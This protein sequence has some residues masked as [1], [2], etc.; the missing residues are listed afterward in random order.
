MEQWKKTLFSLFLLQMADP[1]LA[2]TLGKMFSSHIVLQAEPQ[3][4]FSSPTLIYLLYVDTFSF[5]LTLKYLSKWS[6]FS[7]SKLSHFLVVV[8]I[9][10]WLVFILGWRGASYFSDALASLRPLLFGKFFE[11]QI[12]SESISENVIGLCQYHKY[13]C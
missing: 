10:V 1:L 4:P 7:F 6:L 11:L 12:T 9:I 5:V 3:V 13:Q 8:S 2:L